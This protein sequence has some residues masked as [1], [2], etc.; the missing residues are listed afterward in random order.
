MC[1][2]TSLVGKKSVVNPVLSPHHIRPINPLLMEV[3]NR[4]KGQK[5]IIKTNYYH[6]P[7]RIVYEISNGGAY[8]G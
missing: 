4:E 7:K 6:R 2:K 1:A 8:Y 3:I 5:Y